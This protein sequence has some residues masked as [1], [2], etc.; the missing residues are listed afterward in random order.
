MNRALS[1][2]L[3]HVGFVWEKTLLGC[4]ILPHHKAEMNTLYSHYKAN[5]DLV[6]ATAGQ[7]S[8]FAIFVREYL[9]STLD[10][11]ILD[12]GCGGGSLLAFLSRC[13]YENLFGVEQRPDAAQI[14]LQRAGCSVKNEEIIS[15]LGATRELYDCIILF[16][17]LEHVAPEQLTTVSLLLERHLSPSGVVVLHIPNA[18]GIFGNRV[19]YSDLTHFQA[20]TPESIR[21]FA[22]YGSMDVVAIAEDCPVVHGL[23]SGGRYILWKLLTMPFRFVFA[24]ETGVLNLGYPMSQNFTAVLRKA[25]GPDLTS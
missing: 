12:L 13:G 19:R 20:F 17:V 21:Q 3:V 5:R 6:D 14:A 18:A 8:Y 2:E 23:I 4:A 24:A 10:A 16:D 7:L 15:F 11:R 25:S 9:P 22:S 1:E